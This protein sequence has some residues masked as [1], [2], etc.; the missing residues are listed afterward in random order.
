MEQKTSTSTSTSTKAGAG[1]DTIR[2]SGITSFNLSAIQA[3]HIESL[4]L[5][6]DTSANNVTL[7][8]SA[9]K[10]LVSLGNSSILNLSLGG[11][12]SYNIAAESNVFFTDTRGS[13][14][15]YSDAAKTAQIA[16]VLYV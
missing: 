9:I 16:Q 7:S 1:A 4:D 8:S 15:F 3:T 5:K 6:T 11:N 12:D 13:T 2:I 10:A 14:I